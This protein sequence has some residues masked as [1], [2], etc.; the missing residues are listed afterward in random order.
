M[1][2]MENRYIDLKVLLLILI[3]FLILTAY[4]QESTIIPPENYEII[5]NPD[6]STT[7]INK[8]ESEKPFIA[9]NQE[10][11]L[12][13]GASIT[14]SRDYRKFELKGKGDISLYGKKLNGIENA[15]L[16]TDDKGNI[17]FAHFFSPKGGEY[18]F[19]YNG[20][21]F[22]FIVGENG[23][24]VLFNPKDRIITG[25]NAELITDDFQI[26][27]SFFKINLNENKE[28]KSITLKGLSEFKY[29]GKTFFSE[30]EFEIF[31]DN[32]DI[33]NKKNALSINDNIIKI[34]GRVTM[35]NGLTY[36]PLSDNAFTEFDNSN[37]IFNILAGDV[38]LG[39]KKHTIRIE[40]GEAKL[41]FEELDSMNN[42]EEFS[43]FL[44][45]K[46]GKEEYGIISEDNFY[47]TTEDGKKL[48]SI[49][50]NEWEERMFYDFDETEKTITELEFQLEYLTKK[51]ATTEEKN[52]I[53]AQ[54]LD[55]RNMLLLEQG[56]IDE[57]I[58][59]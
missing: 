29:K 14:V 43:Y 42:I 58:E 55:A 17:V 20:K 59:K 22:V 45:D 49:S 41:K 2:N 21:T 12:E 15:L 32:S 26:I 1:N 38:E 40:N 28:I 3:L 56:E 33:S 34:K 52:T 24:D 9:E 25:E 48:N 30:Q 39:N 44:T 23:G 37:N 57:A 11:K 10:F 13:I 53:K 54:L 4:A 6:G 36:N 18:L 35:N 31:F 8:G 47:F 16:K 7:I 5:E 27:S 19:E 46:N 51:G 50:L